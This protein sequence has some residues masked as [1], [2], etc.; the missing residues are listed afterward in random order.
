MV[1]YGETGLTLAEQRL[2]SHR[3][4]VPG[5]RRRGFLYLEVSIHGLSEIFPA[6]CPEVMVP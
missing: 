3:P 1:L 6:F 4:W 5:M 2:W